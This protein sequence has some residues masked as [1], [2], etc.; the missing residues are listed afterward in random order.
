M[1]ENNSNNK[2]SVLIFF[3]RSIELENKDYLSYRAKKIECEDIGCYYKIFNEK[4]LLV[5]VDV[6]QLSREENLERKEVEILKEILNL[7]NKLLPVKEKELLNSANELY[8]FYHGNDFKGEKIVF[9]KTKVD[10]KLDQPGDTPKFTL[11]GS[12]P[13]SQ[14]LYQ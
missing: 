2:Q 12:I 1:T 13:K 8:V 5:F 10:L 4:E 14:T 3:T 11:S 6:D 9:K 7:L